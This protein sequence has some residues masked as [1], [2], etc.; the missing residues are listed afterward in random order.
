MYSVTLNLSPT[1]PYF[2]VLPS[3][4]HALAL[5][6]LRVHCFSSRNQSDTDWAG[7]AGKRM[8]RLGALF[9]VALC[10]CVP[11]LAAETTLQVFE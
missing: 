6:S 1:Y 5:L 10:K 11:L 7:G 9:Q 2:L 4:G 3:A 8:A